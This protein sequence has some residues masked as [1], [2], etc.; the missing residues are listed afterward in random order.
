MFCFPVALSS[1]KAPGFVY[2]TYDFN[3]KGNIII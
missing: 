2:V 1:V 3:L